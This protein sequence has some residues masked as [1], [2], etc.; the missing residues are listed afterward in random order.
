MNKL[1]KRAEKDRRGLFFII[2]SFGP[3]T[4]RPRPAKNLLLP[5]IEPS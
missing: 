5:T 2:L 1:E 4:P 3:S